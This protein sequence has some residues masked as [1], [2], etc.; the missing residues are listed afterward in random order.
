[1]GF[2]QSRSHITRVAPVL[3][4]GAYTAGQQ[5]GEA[6]EIR[7]ALSTNGSSSVIA[8]CVLLDKAKQTQPFDLV[9]FD[10]LPA[11]GVDGATE[12]ITDAEMLKQL[13]TLRFLA[14]DYVDFA[15]NTQ[16]QTRNVGLMVDSNVSDSSALTNTRRQTSIWG[17][18]VA[19][20]TI[21]VAA[22]SDWQFKIGFLQE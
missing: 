8:S 3:T 9:L 12:G 6:F 7:D 10:D 15:A 19:R 11:T 4:D 5:M 1:M 2:K 13:G 20:G 18:L 21:N 17:V 16:V 22:P 14:A